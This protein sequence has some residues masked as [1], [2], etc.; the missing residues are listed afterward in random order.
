MIDKNSD[1]LYNRSMLLQ[2][3]RLQIIISNLKKSG[4]VRVDELSKILS[5]SENSIRRDLKRLEEQKIVERIHGG[6]ILINQREDEIVPISKRSRIHT[7]EKL[8]IA[9]AALELIEPNMTITL[10]AGSTVSALAEKINENITFPL[11]IITNSLETAAILE[12]NTNFEMLVSGG[13]ISQNQRSL[14]GPYAESFFGRIH[15]DMLFLGASGI[16]EKTGL[17]NSNMVEVGVKRAMIASARRTIA[18][19]DSSKIDHI[20]TYPIADID[21]ID[22]VITDTEVS[23]ATIATLKSYKQSLVIAKSLKLM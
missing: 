11:T 5:T 2:G 10:D 23:D 3:E 16:A 20:A 9:L 22:T 1:R 13:A 17:T 6:A 12:K 15:A 8:S 7:D 14:I 18:L 4:V 21:D 19:L